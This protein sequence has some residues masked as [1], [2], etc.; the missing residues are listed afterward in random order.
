L[1]TA[2][3]LPDQQAGLSDEGEVNVG[4]ELLDQQAMRKVIEQET[5]VSTT[6]QGI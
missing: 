3:T 6:I 1:D 2:H 5:K 4:E